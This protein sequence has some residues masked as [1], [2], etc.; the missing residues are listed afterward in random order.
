MNILKK[1]LL[2]S[3]FFYG[4]SCFSQTFIQAYADVVNQ[5]SQTNINNSLT[6]FES[7]GMKRRGT[8]ALQNTL[9]W[10]KNQ[11]LS[12]G[13]SS[14]QIQEDSY[15]YSGS[16]ATCKNLIVT[17]VGTLYPNTYVIVCGHYDSIG[18]KGTNDNGSGISCILETARL[19]QNVQTDYSIKFINFSGE[20]DGLYGSQHYVTSVVN[21]T[22]PKMSIRLVLNLDEVGGVAGMTNDTITCE[23]DENNS[24]STNNATSA[25]M[26]TQLMNCVSLYSPLQTNLSYA[27]SSDYMPFQ[28]NNEIITGLFET[29]ETTHKHTNTD[30]LIY[31]DPAYTFNVAKAT[32]GATLHFAK[33]N[34]ASMKVETFDGNQV[35]FFPN[36]TK[37]TI[38]ISIGTLETTAYTFSLIDTNGKIV[39]ETLFENPKL[40]ESIPLKGLAK[41][42]Y[43]AVVQTENKRV[44][45]KIVVE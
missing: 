28:S 10:L 17:K 21:G 11:Y 35:Q 4:S 16:T 14:A 42:M 5:C 43:L 9:D 39:L 26:T 34:V 44:T 45:K 25:T 32:I 23:R 33:A 1:S 24:P 41:G 36:P 19:L 31:M 27:Y 3:A 38:Q 22:T 37:D 6:S 13:Y 29:N 18:G 12:Y 8:I 20:E 15:T 30:L 2:I 40:I 7:L